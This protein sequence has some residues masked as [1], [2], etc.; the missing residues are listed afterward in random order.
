MVRTLLSQGSHRSSIL[1]LGTF[2]TNEE[3]KRII[4]DSLD[5]CP[6]GAYCYFVKLNDKWAAKCYRSRSDRDKGYKR[7]TDCFKHELA[8]ET[9]FCFEVKVNYY[10]EDD[11]IEVRHLFCYMTEIIKPCV[12]YDL[13]ED[14]FEFACDTFEAD[15]EKDCRGISDLIEDTIGWRPKDIHGY[16]WGW[17]D[18]K[19]QLLDFV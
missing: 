2:V 17:N 4:C 15:Y 13:I 16:N 6:A 3:I 12:P 5:D 8:P 19:L 14:D 9:G 10:D 7:Q 1:P 18:G 11:D